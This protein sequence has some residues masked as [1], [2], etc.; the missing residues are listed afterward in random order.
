MP[1]GFR[2]PPS[3]LLRRQIL[4]LHLPIPRASTGAA[5]TLSRAAAGAANVYADPSWAAAPAGAA[6]TAD[7]DEVRLAAEPSQELG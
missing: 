6:G 4:R 2:V 3:W 7:A 5:R 1:V